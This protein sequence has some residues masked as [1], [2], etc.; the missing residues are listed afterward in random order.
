MRP[1]VAPVGQAAALMQHFPVVILSDN[2]HRT[3]INH[4]IRAAA[5]EAATSEAI[6]AQQQ[7]R[8]QQQ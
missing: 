1:Q 7:R 4:T 8:R 3:S 6:A 5:A 2:M